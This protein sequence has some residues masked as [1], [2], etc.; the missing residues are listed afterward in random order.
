MSSPTA[1]SYDNNTKN[2]E[3]TAAQGGVGSSSSIAAKN[4]NDGLIGTKSW[5]KKER[6]REAP[7]RKFDDLIMHGVKPWD[8]DAD[9]F[10]ESLLE[11]R[12]E[13]DQWLDNNSSPPKES[14]LSKFEGSNADDFHEA[15]GEIVPHYQDE[16]SEINP[17][18][19]SGIDP[20]Q[21]ED[22]GIDP[23]EDSVYDKYQDEGSDY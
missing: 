19:D 21:G 4:K 20:C 23:Y 17:C 2:W 1:K 8:L 13:L 16:D 10:Y 7:V 3:R 5:F 11:A 22:Y 18:Q 6:P 14:S 9:D 12:R 15:G